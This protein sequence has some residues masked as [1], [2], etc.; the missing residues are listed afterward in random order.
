MGVKTDFSVYLV[1]GLDAQGN[2]E[3]GAYEVDGEML[4]NQVVLAS[5][6]V[7][8]RQEWART[9][10]LIGTIKLSEALI[11]TTTD[12]ATVDSGEGTYVWDYS[13]DACPDT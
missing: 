5:Y 10:D 1:G 3:V 8:I 12:R 13:Q 4:T 11:A 9:N 6:E 7:D 2:C